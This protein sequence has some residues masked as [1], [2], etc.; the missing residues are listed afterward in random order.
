VLLL[1]RL[2]ERRLR[3]RSGAIDL[4]G[5]EEIR[6]DRSRF[7]AECLLATLVLDDDV[8]ADNIGRHEV[9][10]ELDASELEVHRLPERSHEHRLAKPRHAFEE[11]VAS[12]E[13]GDQHSLEDLLLTNH[14]LRHLVAHAPEHGAEA[15]DLRGGF[16][17]GCETGEVFCMENVSK[18]SAAEP[19]ESQGRVC[20][21]AHSRGRIDSKYRLIRKREPRGMFSCSTAFSAAPA[22]A[23]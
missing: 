18:R 15:L 20:S 19:G 22:A 17:S 6:K 14:H 1:H 12:S 2:E 16:G 5:K 13:E 8:R 10:R 4:I 23:S 7:E 21:A 11:H 3:L 9:G